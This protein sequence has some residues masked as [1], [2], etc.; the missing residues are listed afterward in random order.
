MESKCDLSM[1]VGSKHS[2]ERQQHAQKSEGV[3]AGGGSKSFK[4]P[5]IT[6]ADE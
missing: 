4:H 5:G 3:V 1:E 6:G 2:Q